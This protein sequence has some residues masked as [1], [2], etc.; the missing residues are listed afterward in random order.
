[1][2]FEGKNVVTVQTKPS[3]DN[4][5]ADQLRTPKLKSH[6]RTCSDNKH[7]ELT[8]ASKTVDREKIV[9]AKNDKLKHKIDFD[10][11]IIDIQNGLQ[12][13]FL[14][15]GPSSPVPYSTVVSSELHSLLPPLRKDNIYTLVLDLDETLV[16]FNAQPDGSGEFFIRPHVNE[17][18][19]A[20][21][22]CFEVVIF[23]AA[24]K[25]YADFIIDHI[26]PGKLISHRLYR[27][28]TSYQNQ[29]YMKVTVTLTLGSKEAW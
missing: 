6:M 17:F 7:T 20:V 13:Q 28:H 22:R 23:T 9:S 4:E 21:S 24:T 12:K 16:H 3:I 11:I 2:Q 10:K 8:A 14:P 27:D 26:D 29:V 25:E 19:A 1:M 18:L 15:A 5:A